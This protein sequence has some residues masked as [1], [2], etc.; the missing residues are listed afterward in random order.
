MRQHLTEDLS[1]LQS[2]VLTHLSELSMS[3]W[4]RLIMN[5]T[6][7]MLE[8]HPLMF[9]N[10]SI[11][12]LRILALLNKWVLLC[13]RGRFISTEITLHLIEIPDY[14]CLMF[15]FLLLSY[16]SIQCIPI[17]LHWIL[18]IVIH[19]GLNCIV[20]LAW[21][22]LPLNTSSSVSRNSLTYGCCRP[23]STVNRFVGLYI[24]VL[25]TKSIASSFPVPKNWAKLFFFWVEM[26]A[27]TYSANGAW[28][29]S[30]S[31]P[32]GRPINSIIRSI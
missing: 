18:V 27:N 10:I 22:T 24:N 2:S 20:Y 14:Q 7:R 9:T 5:H 21:Q 30:K 4:L 12:W 29:A 11:R 31:S 19:E 13:W 1:L 6:I 28:I 23:Y 8:I 16:V 26:P 32:L 17:F 15:Q 3:I 25:R